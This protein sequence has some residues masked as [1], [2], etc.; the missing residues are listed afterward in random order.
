MQNDMKKIK[1]RK[2]CKVSGL[3][4]QY[5]IIYDIEKELFKIYKL[6]SA[7]DRD[8]YPT[9]HRKMIGTTQDFREA[10]LIIANAM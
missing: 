2:V 7:Y 10:V 5:D 8:G 4:H 6:V 3:G 1:S 9:K